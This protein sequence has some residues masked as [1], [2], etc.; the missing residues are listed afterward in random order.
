M[1]VI[2]ADQVRSRHNADEAGA[3]VETINGRYGSALPLPVDRTAGDEIQLIA[4]SGEIA[5]EVI[6]LLARSGHWSIGLGAGQ[7]LTP[8]PE[9]TREATGSAFISARDAVGRAKKATLRFAVDTDTSGILPGTGTGTGT[10]TG[11]DAAPA[12]GSAADTVEALMNLLLFIRSRRTPEGWEL[13]DL[14]A[15][16]ATQRAAAS[17]LGITP[18]AASARASA[19]GIRFDLAAQPSLV[20]LL[21]ELDRLSTSE[22]TTS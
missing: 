13:F 16:G 18:Q 10:G 14:V 2:T 6:L 20:R 11:Q 1:L 21:D 19:A 3:A 15:A 8:L 17:E 12:A 22:E 9:A 4:P 7:V 5:L